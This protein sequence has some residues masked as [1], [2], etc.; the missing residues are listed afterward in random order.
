MRECEC[1][2]ECECV[3]ECVSVCVR[4]CVC[5]CASV[6]TCFSIYDG[7]VRVG[8]GARLTHELGPSHKSDGASEVAYV[9]GA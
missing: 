4:V 9:F 3:C 1:E 8:A 6:Y 2:C 5:V 7:Y